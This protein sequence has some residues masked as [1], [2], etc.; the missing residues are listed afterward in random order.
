LSELAFDGHCL[1]L[2]VE[3]LRYPCQSDIF[4]GSFLLNDF[5]YFLQFP[6]FSVIE[7]H[8]VTTDKRGA[9]RSKVEEL[10]LILLYC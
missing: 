3:I 9:Y 6:D 5:A 1:E 10:G 4:A 7:L 2:G 8:E